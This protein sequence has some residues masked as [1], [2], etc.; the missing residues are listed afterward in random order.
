MSAPQEFLDAIG[1]VPVNYEIMAMNWKRFDEGQR[2]GPF[3]MG[4][5]DDETMLFVGKDNQSNW[6]RKYLSKV[7]DNS[8]AYDVIEQ[9]Y[10]LEFTPVPDTGVLAT[11]MDDHEAL[12]DLAEIVDTKLICEHLRKG[13]ASLAAKGFGF[14][15]DG[16]LMLTYQITTTRVE[17]E[18]TEEGYCDLW[19][20]E[21][22]GILNMGRLPEITTKASELATL[23]L[24]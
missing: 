20:V 8:Q 9:F 5:F 1:F 24:G 4:N 23:D 14:V 19:Q 22:L 13:D 2:L 10:M 6:W 15:R 18:E 12:T 11:L 16:T 3:D 17:D 21:T 7:D